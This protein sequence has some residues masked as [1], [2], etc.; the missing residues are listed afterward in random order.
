MKKIY[1]TFGAGQQN[2]GCYTVIEAEDWSSA[3]NQMNQRFGNK[4]SFQYDESQWILGPDSVG[5]KSRAKLLG[6]DVDKGETI[7]QAEMY[8]LKRI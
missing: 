8:N 1:F 4:W 6:L 3:R 2:E 7:T 5:Y